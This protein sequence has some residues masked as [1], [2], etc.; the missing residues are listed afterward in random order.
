MDNIIVINDL[1]FKYDNSIVFNN[2]SLSIEKG[3]FTTI[4]GNNGSGKSTLVKI[5]CGLL[6]FDGSVTINGIDLCKKNLKSIRRNIGF[7]FENPDNCLISETVLED[8]AF[9][10]ENLNLS[11]DYI[12]SKIVEISNYLGI[13][14]LLNKCSRDL[15]GG[16][17]QLVSLACA[18]VTGPKIL[19][20]DEALSMLDLNNK[21]KILLILKKIKKDFGVTI[22]NVT[23]DIEESVYGDDI[24]LI[25]NGNIILHDSKKNVYKCEKVLGKYGF[26]L[27]FMV[28]LSN[29]LSYYDLIDNY[30]FDM[31]KM[32]DILWK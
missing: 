17:K 13:S 24:L 30:V 8:L 15:S 12:Y 5:L 31:N 1:C 4:L 11:R 20:L 29:R 6:D 25:D 19:I 10:L 2:F 7:V 9:P 18:L 32:V 22:I 23:H 27:P 3:K 26:D 14:D 21:K 28:D 16:E